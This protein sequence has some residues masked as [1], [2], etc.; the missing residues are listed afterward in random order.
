MAVTT[1]WAK[2]PCYDDDLVW[3]WTPVG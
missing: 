2:T 3:R 1:A